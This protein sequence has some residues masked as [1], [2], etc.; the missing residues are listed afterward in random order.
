MSRMNNN[1]LT[2]YLAKR[3]RCDGDDLRANDLDASIGANGPTETKHTDQAEHWTKKI[4]EKVE[5]FNK[6]ITDD[7]REMYDPPHRENI[8]A[9]KSITEETREYFIYQLDK[10]EHMA[11]MEMDAYPG[12]FSKRRTK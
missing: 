10:Q 8:L 6:L 7:F 4:D 3:A 9:D 2:A 1:Q 12:K 5:R 11:D